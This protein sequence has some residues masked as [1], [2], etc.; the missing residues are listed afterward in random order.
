MNVAPIKVLLV[1][2]DPADARSVETKL[3]AARIARFTVTHVVQTQEAMRC[4]VEGPPDVVLLGS[5]DSNGLHA[6]AR[7]HLQAPSVPII[8]LSAEDDETV[9]L[10]AMREGRRIIS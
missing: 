10:E 8:V 2:A 4:L 3:S 1:E 7:L 9:A 6:M 5:Q